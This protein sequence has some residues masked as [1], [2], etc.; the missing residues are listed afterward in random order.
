MG[1]CRT[2]FMGML[3]V[4]FVKNFSNFDGVLQEDFPLKSSF[5]K[6]KCIFDQSIGNLWSFS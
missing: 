4:A 1:V 3:R 2:C 6:T 5:D